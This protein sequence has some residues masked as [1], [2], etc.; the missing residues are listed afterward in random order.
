MCQRLAVHAD[1]GTFLAVDAV[2]TATLRTATI[3][4]VLRAVAHVNLG[5]LRERLFVHAVE[6]VR[7]SKR[8]ISKIPYVDSG[9]D[10]S[11]YEP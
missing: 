11:L 8:V 6:L 5:L 4:G 1:L 3:F 7:L 9:Q 2:E 10:F